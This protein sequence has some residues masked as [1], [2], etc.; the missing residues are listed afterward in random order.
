MRVGVPHGDGVLVVHHVFRPDATLQIL[1][2]GSVLPLHATALGK[3]VLAYLDEDT[4]E[5]LLTDELTR[6]TGHTLTGPAAVRRELEFVRDAR[7]RPS[8]ARRRS[9]AKV[10]SPRRSSPG[11]ASRSERSGSQARASGSCVAG[12][13]PRSRRT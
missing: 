12:A 11:Q 4:V 10:A 5:E 9:S 2:V 6:L 1:E 7:L 3:A 8:S 13:S